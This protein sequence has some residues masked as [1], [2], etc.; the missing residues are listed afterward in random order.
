MVA[1]KEED[2]SRRHQVTRRQFLAQAGI[3]AAGLM[4]LGGC[5]HFPALFAGPPAP[6][7]LLTRRRRVWVWADTHIGLGKDGKDGGE[8]AELSIR[9]MQ[10][11]LAAPDYTLVL[12]DITH[13]Y[14]PEE[15]R[16]YARLREFSGWP[17]WYELVGNHDFNGTT[18]GEYWRHVRREER[19][20]LLDGNVAW[21]LV[22]AERGKSDGILRPPTRAWL[23][24][25]V[26]KHQDKNV[27]VC[28]HQLVENTLRDSDHDG[29]VIYPD[30]WI[31]QL[32][33]DHRIDVWLCGHEH[34]GRRD[35]RQ[36]RKIGRTLFV[37][38]ASLSHAYHT[39]A[40]NSFLFEM[41]AGER[42]FDARCRH[43]DLEK[44]VPT[45]S[46]RVELAYAMR[47]DTRPRIVDVLPPSAY[48]PRAAR[49]PDKNY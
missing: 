10:K 32:L 48:D 34:A 35:R 23:K 25:V 46:T 6:P 2:G 14:R 47:F 29:A 36:I 38:V 31:K 22:S 9:E 37:N 17:R 11:N 13:R 33:K 30:D 28:T 27:I 26:A 19:Y 39:R 40:C 49:R 15:F 7:D 5:R 44:Y 16:E 12:G 21:I 8:W 3:G 4:A 45:L 18:S 20:V 42:A 24:K 43:H 41:N 1:V